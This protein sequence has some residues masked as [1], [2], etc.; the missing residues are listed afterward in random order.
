[1]GQAWREGD[2]MRYSEWVKFVLLRHLYE[3]SRPYRLAAYTWHFPFHAAIWRAQTSLP[4]PQLLCFFWVPH[5]DSLLTEQW[6][7]WWGLCIAGWAPMSE[8]TISTSS[9]ASIK[10][11]L[12]AKQSWETLPNSVSEESLSARKAAQPGTLHSQAKFPLVSPPL[13]CQLINPSFSQRE[14]Q[15]EFWLWKVSASNYLIFHMASSIDMQFL[16][17][18]LYILQ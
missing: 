17:G 15:A 11:G 13:L 7:R 12:R 5:T 16:V 1:M 18:S 9:E 14:V 6:E 8:G 4:P 10:P 2:L 3:I